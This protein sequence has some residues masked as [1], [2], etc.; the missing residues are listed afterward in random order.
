MSIIGGGDDNDTL[1]TEF[2]KDVDPQVPKR[3]GRQPY[4]RD[5]SGNIIRPDGT[6]SKPVG[7]PKTKASLEMQISG[8]VTLINMFVLSFKSSMA[9]DQTEST[10]LI[11]AIDAE[12]Q[13]NARFRKYVE[14]I[15][16][17]AGSVNL[18]SVVL[19]IVGR[20]VVR[21]GV[22]PIPDDSPVKA[23]AIDNLLGTIL[24]A[25]TMQKPIATMNVEA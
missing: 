11:K 17:G 1:I 9:L 24:S 16:K 23:D 14:S 6:I 21:A 19:I 22:L 20:R 15:V 7:R 3:R 4:P 18:L 10:A 8:F 5:A 12:C 13:V 25:T 2:D